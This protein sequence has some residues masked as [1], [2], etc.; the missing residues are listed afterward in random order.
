VEELILLP[1]AAGSV[2]PLLQVPEAP[3]EIQSS[4]Y[5]TLSLHGLCRKLHNIALTIAISK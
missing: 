2:D 5:L 1:V 3:Q 4:P